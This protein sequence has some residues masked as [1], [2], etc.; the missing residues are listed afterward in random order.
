MLTVGLIF[1]TSK[2]G[3]EVNKILTEK[4]HNAEKTEE[5]EYGKQTC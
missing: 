1:G 2:E 3:V 5:L 4:Q